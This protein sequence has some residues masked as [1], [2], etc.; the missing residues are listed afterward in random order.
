MHVAVRDGRSLALP[1]HCTAG[2]D[3]RDRGRQSREQENL[4]VLGVC[5]N[6]AG[7]ALL[8]AVGWWDILSLALRWYSRFVLQ[9]LSWRHS[10][11]DQREFQ[12]L[13]WSLPTNPSRIQWETRRW[14]PKAGMQWRQYKL[15][16]SVRRTLRG[17]GL[18]GR[19][20]TTSV[21]RYGS[22]AALEKAG[23]S[24]EGGFGDPWFEFVS[25]RSL[26]RYF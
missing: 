12:R 10:S 13:F 14:H 5:S 22:S 9:G 18:I 25:R 17:Y 2:D 4:H 16:W 20:P 24:I 8:V 3:C 19:S 26:S 15:G 11:A 21:D 7:R 6:W 23:G 1:A